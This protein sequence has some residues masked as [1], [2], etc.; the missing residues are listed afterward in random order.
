MKKKDS[1]QEIAKK[2]EY[3]GLNLDEIPATLKIVEDLQFKPSVGFDE[4][5]YRQ[6][7]YVSPKEIEILLSPTNRLDEVKDKYSKYNKD[8]YEFKNTKLYI[9][10]GIGTSKYKFRL[11]NRPSI[12]FY[13][14]RNK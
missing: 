13:R 1:E 12:N 4:K 6:Y 3:I 9:S 14:L 10:S 7:R 5:K 2:L 8:F 11:L